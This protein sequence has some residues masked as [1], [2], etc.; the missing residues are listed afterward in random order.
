MNPS[1]AQYIAAER[2]K[3]L[4]RQAATERLAKQARDT[5]PVRRPRLQWPFI[6]VARPASH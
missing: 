2:T 3:D 5:Q 6:P 1:I 4:H